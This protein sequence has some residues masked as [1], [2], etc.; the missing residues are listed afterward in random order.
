MHTNYGFYADPTCTGK[1]YVILSLLALSTCVERKKL[2]TVWSNGLGMS[3]YSKIKNFEI[4]LSILVT[5]LGSIGQWSELFQKETDIKFLVVDEFSKIEKIN[6]YDYEVLLV[7]D[8][9]F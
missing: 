1:S 3:V 9:V 8:E 6:S 2:L 7:A 4:P 5:P